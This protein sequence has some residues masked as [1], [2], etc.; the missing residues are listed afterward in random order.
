M[1]ERVDCEEEEDINLELDE[2]EFRGRTKEMGREDITR[3]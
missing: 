2:K 3:I 1:T